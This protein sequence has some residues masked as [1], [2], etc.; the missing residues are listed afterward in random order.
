[1][2]RRSKRDALA[3][4]S[5]TS[6]YHEDLELD[7]GTRSLSIVRSQRILTADYTGCLIPEIHH[8]ERHDGRLHIRTRLVEFCVSCA[9]SLLMNARE[10]VVLK[11]KALSSL[12]IVWAMMNAREWIGLD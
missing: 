9:C 8:S 1:M 11:R 5:T 6:T 7:Y 12:M 3:S 4:R 2:Q 10:L